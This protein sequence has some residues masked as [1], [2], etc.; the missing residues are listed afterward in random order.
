[1]RRCWLWTIWHFFERLTVGLF[2]VNFFRICNKVTLSHYSW[3]HISTNFINF[4]FIPKIFYGRK[5]ITKHQQCSQKFLR[6]DG[7]LKTFE[8]GREVGSKICHETL[9]N[10]RNFP[11][12]KD[13]T[14]FRLSNSP[15]FSGV[16]PV[17]L[18]N[19]WSFKFQPIAN[20]KFQFHFKITW[21]FLT[22][23]T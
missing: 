21:P 4:Q 20:N 14:K 17:H 3:V 23:V 7:R 12:E 18:I 10:W 19:F 2:C 1:M 16:L 22:L 15:I 5:F 6:A 9:A 13:N 11:Q 8:V